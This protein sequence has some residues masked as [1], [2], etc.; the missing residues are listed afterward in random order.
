MIWQAA[1]P[2]EEGKN[3]MKNVDDYKIYGLKSKNP[4]IQVAVAALLF[5]LTVS[6]PKLADAQEPTKKPIPNNRTSEGQP[7]KPRV[8]DKDVREMPT[9]ERWKP[10]DPVRE[11]P[12]INPRSSKDGE[13]LEIVPHRVEPSLDPLLERQE[14]AP[15]ED[16]TRS[17]SPPDV[18]VEGISFTGAFPPDMVGDVGPNHYIQMVND[19][20]GGSVFAIYDKTGHLLAGPT[21]LQTLDTNPP[22]DQCASGRGDPIVLYDPLA[23]RWLMSEFSVLSNVLCVYISQTADP[24]SGGWFLYEFPTPSV[25]DYPKYAVWPDAYYVSSNEANQDAE[26]TPAAYALDRNQMIQ[27]LP[28]TFQRFTAPPLAGFGF[29]A[30]LP[31]DLD[32][33]TPPP[34]SSPNFFVRHRDDEVHGA[35]TPSVPPNPFDLR[36]VPL[37]FK[38]DGAA[39]FD[40]ES[41]AQPLDGDLGSDLGLFDDDSIEQPL[42]FTFPFRGVNYTSVFVNSNGNLT[43]GD[44]DTA[45]NELVA[46]FVSGAPR[47]AP[48]WDDLN[49]EAGGGVFFKTL[50]NPNRVLI[51]WSQI[52]EFGTTNSNTAQLTLFESGEITIRYNGVD[53]ADALVGVGPGGGVG[54]LNEL[55]F[56]EELPQSG[57]AGSTLELFTLEATPGIPGPADPTQD[58]LEIWEFQVDFDNAANSSLTG[59]TQ[60]PISEFD[61]DL[62]GLFSAFCF[63]QPDTDTTLDPLR[64]VIMWRL[65]YRNFGTHETLVGNFVTDVDGTEHGGIR[66]FE[67]RK[68]GGG[69]W[70]LFQEGTHSP[71]DASRWMGGI[72]MDKDNNIALAYSVSNENVFPSIR[73]AGR[74][75]SDPAGTL[76]QGEVS[77]IDGTFSQT[78]ATRWGDY[79]SMNVDPV[80]DCTFWYTNEY[81]ATEDTTPDGIGTWGTR[82]A[83]FRFPSCKAPVRPIACDPETPG[84]IIGT[85]GND[86]LIGTKGDD[87]FIGLGGNDRIIGRGGNDCIDSGPGRDVILTGNGSDIILAGDGNDKVITRAGNDTVDGGAGKDRIITGR[88]TDTIRAGEG[89]DVVFAGADNDTVDGGDGKDRIKGGSGDDTIDGGPDKDTV[90]GGSGFDTCV[91]EETSRNCEE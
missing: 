61:S 1:K 16:V 85:A 11:V 75:Q 54:D 91:N 26:P 86:R 31:G 77:I 20:S 2:R 49:P 3:N 5:A 90:N 33:S 76:P 27:G 28:A 15:R 69:S 71:D 58:V 78:G 79:S 68:T 67:L 64:E 38:P 13:S 47:I 39:G 18:N 12:R 22:Q 45:F 23:D 57:L 29:Q 36:D 84:A 63:P 55:D 24:M 60:I 62:C 66:W 35:F 52:P 72:S 9:V 41:S 19:S 7:V 83:S 56:S 30:L 53:L 40:V 43:F 73:Y 6:I 81:V 4:K 70:A 17:I 50:T 59:P 10:G 65:Q 89:N 48:F 74:L 14:R 88:G 37:L 82:I 8:M 87:V 32:G 80:D 34:A 46:D 51:T 21:S 42:G 25:P 44:G